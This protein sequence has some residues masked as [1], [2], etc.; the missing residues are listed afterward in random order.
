[1]PNGYHP[2]MIYAV[3]IGSEKVG[4]LA[5]CRLPESPDTF[6]SHSLESLA[7]CITSDLTAGYDVAVGFECPLVIEVRK[8]PQDLT[9][10]RDNEGNRPWSA[11]AGASALATG[12]AQIAWLFERLP[13]PNT[14]PTFYWE[15]LV[16]G[17]ANLLIWEA[18]VTN[19]PP[20]H[21]HL[22]DARAAATAFQTQVATYGAPRPSIRFEA[23]YSLAGAALLRAGLSADVSLLRQPCIVV[24]PQP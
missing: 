4:R 23:P 15:E 11:G 24:R 18:F 16:S 17:Q 10:A 19:K 7:Q 8:Q 2:L 3:D 6:L 5:W 13:Q 14:R 12:L 21:T 22:G 20:G 9:S 1:M